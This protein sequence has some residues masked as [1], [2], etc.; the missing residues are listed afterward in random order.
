MCR[1]TTALPRRTL[2]I[3]GLVDYLEL[4]DGEAPHPNQRGASY[5]DSWL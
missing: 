2:E 3:A 1:V 4:H 5:D